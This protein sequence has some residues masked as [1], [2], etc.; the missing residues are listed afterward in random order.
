L[1]KVSSSK[2]INLRTT[3]PFPRV[4]TVLVQW[5]KTE[6]VPARNQRYAPSLNL[7]RE[8]CRWLEYP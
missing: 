3:G 4:A 7:K 2:A 8:I 5:R 6:I 1:S